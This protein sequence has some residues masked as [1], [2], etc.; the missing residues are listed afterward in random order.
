MAYRTHFGQLDVDLR[1]IP[2]ESVGPLVVQNLSIKGFCVLDPGFEGVALDR[3][4]TD[5][6]ALNFYEVNGTVADGLLGPEGSASVA[7][8]EATPEAEEGIGVDL[9]MLDHAV[10]RIGYMLQPYVGLANLSFSHRSAGVVHRAGDVLGEPP[11][12]TE[13]E[14]SKW[15]TQFLRHRL[16][17]ILFLGPEVGRLELEPYDAKDADPFVLETTPGTLVVL[18]PDSLSHKHFCPGDSYAL[19]AFFLTDVGRR[20]APEGGWKLNPAA[21]ALEEWTT[22]RLSA[23]KELEAREVEIEVPENWHKAMNHAFHRGQMAGIYGDGVHQTGVLD[24]DSW[25]GAASSGPDYAREVPLLRWDHSQYYDPDPEKLTAGKTCCR[26]GNFADGVELFDN[27]FFDIAIEEAKELDPHQRLI[28]EQGYN[29]LARMGMTKKDLGGSKGGVYVGCEN[30]EWTTQ[31]S[32]AYTSMDNMLAMFSGRVSFCL[33]MKGPAVTLTT[34]GA[35]GLT[36]AHMAA[37][38]VLARGWQRAPT[39]DFA[40][41]I[42]VS[43]M[44]APS[45]WTA[46]AMRSFLSIKGRCRTFDSSADGFIRGEGCAAMAIK[47]ATTIV[48]GAIQPREDKAVLLG[49]IA[50]AASNHNGK[51]ASLTSPHGPSEQECVA[52][53]IRSAAV[54]PRDVEAV[55]AHGLGAPV[56]DAVEVNTHWRAHRRT[57]G[58]EVR[59]PL[60]LLATKTSVG[61]QVEASGALALLKAI[62]SAQWGHMAPLLHLH[63]ANPYIDPFGQP[64]VLASEAV[65]FAGASS[66]TGVMSQGF[67]G[68]NVYVLSWGVE[69]SAKVLPTP[70]VTTPEIAYWP[71]GGGQL[72]R[73]LMPNETDGYFI[74]GTWSKWAD[75]QRMERRGAAEYT[76]E[77]TLGENCWEQF[78]IWLDGKPDRSLHPGAPRMPQG[79]PV[80]GPQP[81]FQGGAE[82][83]RSTLAP[84]WMI[85]GRGGLAA[86]HERGEGIVQRLT[87]EGSKDEE[88]LAGMDMDMLTI[89]TTE[90]G[91]PG[92]KYEVLLEVKGKWRMVTWKKVSAAARAELPTGSSGAYFLGGSWSEWSLEEMRSDPSTPGLF[93]GEIQLPAIGAADF[94][95]VRDMDWSQQ[96]YPNPETASL[97][98]PASVLGPD[99]LGYEFSRWRIEGRPGDRYSV[100]F[101]RS[102]D[103]AGVESRRVTWELQGEVGALADAATQPPAAEAAEQPTATEA[104]APAGADVPEEPHD[105]DQ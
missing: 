30:Q 13:A 39:N 41:A 101:L 15:Q 89:S 59:D 105:S 72:E 46:P 98:D 85:D 16:M 86:G 56:R 92:D 14:V 84:T 104:A 27:K 69:S 66:F 23:L 10:T 45:A 96:F 65:A 60:C 73:D 95:V 67:G 47:A 91:L 26:H 37:E 54:R 19:S 76:F 79:C 35:S 7:D 52:M 32:A 63:A 6:E 17:A 31:L 11:E 40:L 33:N 44:L 70:S 18:C 21:R 48:E 99:D 82:V 8:L 9:R 61:N 64:L 22:Q 24:M 71:G 53:A 3:A 28:L 94:L 100:H 88:A 20:R 1:D 80:L 50:G 58:E 83:A 103:E 90:V 34:E 77:V 87:A 62:Y 68:T 49:T 51:A 75:P 2:P 78:Q 74:V 4:V 5:A 42:G 36:V 55:E 12:L 81:D 102:Y 57:M 38:S 43:L 25:I 93:T 97:E 29:A